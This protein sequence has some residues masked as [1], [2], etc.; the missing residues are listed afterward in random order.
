MG[1]IDD[2][3]EQQAITIAAFCERLK[4][5]AKAIEH[6]MFSMARRN[7]TLK[8][9]ARLLLDYVKGKME[10]AGIK[11]IPSPWFM[12]TI[13]ENS[14]LIDMYDQDSIPAKY[15]KPKIKP[16]RSAIMEALSDGVDVPGVRLV[17]GTRL[18]IG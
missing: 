16:D 8:A 6:A 9:R 1:D 17:H 18:V 12:L 7:E 14:P 11:E 15:L 13:Q 4:A 3:L 10:T 5:E 2:P